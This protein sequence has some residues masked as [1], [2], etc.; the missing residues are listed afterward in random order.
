MDESSWNPLVIVS[1]TLEQ[2]IV[3]TLIQIAFLVVA[4]ELLAVTIG[5]Q[6]CVALG[7]ILLGFVGTRWTRPIAAM[8]PRM[9][10]MTLLLLVTIN[11]VAGV[12]NLLSADIATRIANVDAAGQAGVVAGMATIAAD[13]VVYLFLSLCIT[14]LVGFLGATTPMTAGATLRNAAMTAA[15]FVGARMGAGG[16]AGASSG[17]NS[18]AKIEAA[19]RL[20]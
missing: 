18:I 16:G 6:L 13:S 11:A 9:L 19:T 10:V 2:F 4:I 1:L 7:S 8:W 3:G 12:G 15:S 5:V 20:R 17:A 14:G